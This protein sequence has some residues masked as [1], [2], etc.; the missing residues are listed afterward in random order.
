MLYTLIILVTALAPAALLFWYINYKDK[1]HPE[2]VKL[3]VKGLVYGMLSAFLVGG[4]GSLLAMAGFNLDIES[5]DSLGGAATLS[6]F[7]AALPEEG[8]K[9]FMLW[10]LLRNNKYYDEYL[11]GI[12]YAA[13]VGLGFAGLENVLY[14]FNAQDEWLQVGLM[15]GI[16]AVP[17][18]FTMACAMGYFY[19]EYHFGGKKRTSAA[20]VFLVPVFIHWLWDTLAFS[21]SLLGMSSSLLMDAVFLYFIYRLYKSTRQRIAEMQHK[22]DL[23]VMPPIPGA[24]MPPN[25]QNNQTTIS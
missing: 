5:L 13:C 6:L 21:A 25:E 2:P 1:A 19:S 18:H 3:L 4:Y 15:R 24:P 23:R 10:L 22:D 20:C 11:D 7:G 17:A 16:T 9:L 12:V 8:A 14:L